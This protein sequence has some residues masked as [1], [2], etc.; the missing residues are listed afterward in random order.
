[1]ASAN[2]PP[3]RA[4]VAFVSN[5]KNADGRF[6]EDGR[7]ETGGLPDWPVW[8]KTGLGVAAT[9]RIVV[10]YIS[11]RTDCLRTE[12]HGS[13]SLPEVTRCPTVRTDSL[14]ISPVQANEENIEIYP[15][16]AKVEVPIQRYR[17]GS[18]PQARP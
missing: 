7:D 13:A 1:M 9:S 5:S 4:A 3:S 10:T 18:P 2:R 15:N 11:L 8:A 16:G 12:K 14:S 6:R 17:V